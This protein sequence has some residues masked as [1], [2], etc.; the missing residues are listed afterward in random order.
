MWLRRKHREALDIGPGDNI[1]LSAVVYFRRARC[2]RARG[3]GPGTVRVG[4]EW[5]AP[6]QRISRTEKTTPKL[7]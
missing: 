2:A 5:L 7:R 3:I 6:G 4:C 1:D